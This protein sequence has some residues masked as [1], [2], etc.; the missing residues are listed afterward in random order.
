MPSTS[1]APTETHGP[2]RIIYIQDLS[3]HHSAH[4]YR[5]FLDFETRELHFLFPFP[6]RPRRIRRLVIDQMPDPAQGSQCHAVC[7]SL[8]PFETLR[9]MA[10]VPRLFEPSNSLIGRNGVFKGPRP[11]GLAPANHGFLR[12]SSDSPTPLSRVFDS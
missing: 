5:F 10:T 7:A 1:Y 11:N 4:S 3:K 9:R 8:F 12:P 6:P 2:T